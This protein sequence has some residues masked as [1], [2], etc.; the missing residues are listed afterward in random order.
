ME[1]SHCDLEEKRIAVYA[2]CNGAYM[3]ACLVFLK[4]FSFFEALP[5]IIGVA[6][7]M[8]VIE[9]FTIDKELHISSVVS[10]SLPELARSLC[11]VKLSR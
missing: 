3:V 6:V 8:S 1:D 4:R 9:R 2:A 7:I 5:M 10:M 11:N